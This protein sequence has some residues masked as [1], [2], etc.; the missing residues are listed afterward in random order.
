VTELTMDSICLFRFGKRWK[1]SELGEN[2]NCQ[3][4]EDE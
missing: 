2:L 1:A 4:Y 3:V